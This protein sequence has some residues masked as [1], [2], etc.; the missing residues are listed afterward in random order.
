MS[1]PFITVARWRKALRAGTSSRIRRLVLAMALV[2]PIAAVGS[3]FTSAA[4]FTANAPDNHSVLL[5]SSTL[6]D[7]GLGGDT[8][9][10]EEAQAIADGLT[11]V[12]A[13][14]AD[15]ATMTQA[16]FATYRAVVLGDRT[17]SA[18][19][20]DVA[21]A[22]ANK[23]TWSAAAKGNIIV[24]G[25][26]PTY[27]SRFGGNA[28][29]AQ[30]LI[31][32]GIGFA[33]A[34]PAKTGAYIALGCYYYNA[35][36][37]APVPLLDG[38]GSFTVQGQFT[39]GGS[40]PARSHIVASHPALA[41]LTDA[42]LSNWGCSTHEA[43]DTLPPSFAVLAINEDIPTGYVATDGTAG[44]PY[45]VARGV[46][47]VSDIKLTPDTDTNPVGTSNTVTAT[48]TT[49]DPVPG[50]AVVGTLVTFTVIAGPNAGATGT[51]LTNSSG[52]ATFTYTDTGGAGTDF[53]Q[54]TFI[55]AQGHKQ[56]SNN[57]QKTWEVPAIDCG[58]ANILI[59]V[60][61]LAKSTIDTDVAGL[62]ESFRATATA[63]GTDSVLCIYVDATNTATQLTAGIYSNV[64]GH[65]GALL[66]QGSLAGPP[67]NGAFNTFQIPSVP[68][69]SGTTY[70]IA[71]LSPF[72]SGG[73]FKFRDHCCGFQSYTPSA[74]SENS[75]ETNLAALPAAW[76]TGKIW[77]RDAPILGWGGG[78]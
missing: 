60:K 18:D 76:T 12:I 31:K 66:A 27:H 46:T 24:I 9:S 15:W 11:P 25:T 13:S 73:S 33:A 53:I 77:P 34:D 26:D 22:E 45:I 5:L 58:N 54:A 10:W 59:G 44:G 51:G 1:K 32:N 65:P 8:G 19:L 69:A 71:V 2:V 62:A 49:D 41:G 43:F 6:S 36:V 40:C 74:P 4:S 67:T 50:T 38:F 61:T 78:A 68:L 56:T 70:W 30:T 28:A 17:C 21:A 42:D 37:G 29:G 52:Q 23:A 20:S 7:S 3:Q 75:K 35:A 55:D 47:V 14:P 48:V 63:S 16:N 72:G 64:G 57:A 39:F